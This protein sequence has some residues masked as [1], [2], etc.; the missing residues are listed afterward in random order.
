MLNHKAQALLGAERNKVVL[1]IVHVGTGGVNTYTTLTENGGTL[2]ERTHNDGTDRYRLCL[3]GTH[4]P[5]WWVNHH[6]AITVWAGEIA[7]AHVLTISVLGETNGLVVGRVNEHR[8]TGKRSRQGNSRVGLVNGVG[9]FIG[10]RRLHGLQT[11]T[12]K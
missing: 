3:Y 5:K 4:T 7:T 6:A 10:R 11:G 1:E 9:E 8:V 12:V 2:S